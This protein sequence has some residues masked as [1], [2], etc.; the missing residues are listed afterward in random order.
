MDETPWTLVNPHDLEI[1]GDTHAPPTPTACVLLLHGFLGY[2]DYGFIPLLAR[3]LADAGVL[4]HRFNFSCSGMTNAVE[5]FERPDLFGLDTWSRQVEDVRRVARAVRARELPG[6]DLPLWLIG[7]SRGGDTAILAAGRHAE[8]LGLAGVVTINAPADCNRLSDEAVA[9]ALGEGF[10]EVRSGR[11]GQTMRLGRAWLDEQLA[12][13][14]GHN[15]EL[16][17]ARIDRPVLVL[18]GDADDTVPTEDAGRLA[19]ATRTTPVL[20]T[21]GTHVLN[22]PNPPDEATRAHPG[23]VFEAACGQILARV[24]GPGA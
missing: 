2:K 6:A 23:P 12:D 10:L 22:V 19:A 1:L 9:Q 15:L 8:E 16:Q 13:P 20:L 3:R 5:T 21:D 24:L 7:H 18:Q 11:T 17:A 4:V 14:D